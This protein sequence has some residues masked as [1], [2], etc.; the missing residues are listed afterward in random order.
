MA[1]DA[2]GMGMAAEEF[3]SKFFNNGARPSGVLQH[4]GTLKDPGKLRDAWMA[5][6]G[7]SNNAGKVAVLEEGVKYEPISINPSEAQF[8][9]TRKYQLD[10][11]ARIFRVPPH[12]IGDLEKS[13]FSNIEQ[14]SLEF[15][16]Y[17]LSPWVVRW[18]QTLN[19]ALLLPGEKGRYFVKL[20]VSGLLRGDYQSR[21]N[22]YS[23][24]RQNGWMSANDI[25]E[26]EDLNP[27][28]DEEGGNLYLINGNMCKLKDAG[29]YANNA[30]QKEEESSSDTGTGLTRR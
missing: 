6:Y 4:P 12:M 25:R 17:T 16:V 27:I 18:E 5:A 24:A 8:I 28:P 14:Q 9:Q 23:I 11:I 1:R 13:S 7:G 2:I 29:I 15:V 30:G 22:G 21:M 10:E 19:K 3:G 20:N 26:L